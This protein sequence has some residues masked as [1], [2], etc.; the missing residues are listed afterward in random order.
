MD[1]KMVFDSENHKQIVAALIE[2]ANFPGAI[3]EDVAK[4]KEAVSKAK[5]EAPW[6]P[7]HSKTGD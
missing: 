2:K 7:E 3:V 5:V 4:L 6:V 1:K